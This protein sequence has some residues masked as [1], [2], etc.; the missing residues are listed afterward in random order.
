M[1]AATIAAVSTA[2]VAILG[3]VAGVIKAWQAGKSA[4]KTQAALQ[5]H[6][7]SEH[8]EVKP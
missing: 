1:N 8:V 7:A 4:T 6:L 2:A 3:A 5:D